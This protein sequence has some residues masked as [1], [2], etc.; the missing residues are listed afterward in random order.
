MKQ[1]SA[2]VDP[3]SFLEAYFLV[4]LL[5]LLLYLLLLLL[6]FFFVCFV[7]IGVVDSLE[8]SQDLSSR[9]GCSVSVGQHSFAQMEDDVDRQKLLGQP[10]P[11]R[12]QPISDLDHLTLQVQ[13]YIF[14]F[15]LHCLGY[16]S[17]LLFIPA[18][19]C[20]LTPCTLPPLLTCTIY[21][22]G[23]LVA[24]CYW[25]QFFFFGIISSLI[26][27]ILCPV[28]RTGRQYQLTI[29]GGE[30]C[31]IRKCKE[32]YYDGEFIRIIVINVVISFDGV[33]QVRTTY[34]RNSQSESVLIWD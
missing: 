32:T 10:T 33:Y 34:L 14:I 25:G 15:R 5:L 1:F 9:F 2:E 23:K 11:P 21:D 13:V 12:I 26:I 20:W 30:I 28:W 19:S 16:L 24:L 22:R 27:I 3:P 8:E 18:V 7:N 31:S 17:H 4:L 29:C 6:L